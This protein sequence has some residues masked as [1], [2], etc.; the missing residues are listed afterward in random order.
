MGLLSSIGNVWSKAK[1]GVKTGMK[2]VGDHSEQIGKVL[3]TAANIGSTAAMAMGHPGVSAAIRGIQ[4]GIGKAAK[5]TNEQSNW[6]KFGKA[7]K[8]GST[9]GLTD[10]TAAYIGNDKN[11]ISGKSTKVY[12]KPI[13][14]GIQSVHTVSNYDN[15]IS[16]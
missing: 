4:Y 13:M 8:K 16:W 5:A 14:K 9:K 2:W 3:N 1:S 7:L 12:G 10:S 11:K 15:P 6:H